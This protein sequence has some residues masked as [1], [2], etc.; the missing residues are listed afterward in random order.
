MTYL[1]DLHMT[2]AVL[3]EVSKQANGLAVGL[4]HA[5]PPQAGMPSTVRYLF[6]TSE[7]LKEKLAQ[8]NQ[9]IEDL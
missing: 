3:L 9:L 7:Q 1:D 8:I 2:K 4:Q 6:E 5:A